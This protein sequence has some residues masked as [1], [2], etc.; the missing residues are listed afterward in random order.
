MRTLAKEHRT[1]H[2]EEQTTVIK[3]STTETRKMA[4]TTQNDIITYHFANRSTH[5][6][7]EFGK[8]AITIK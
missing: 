8:V 7:P 5:S 3:K 4:G 2:R 6:D 1:P